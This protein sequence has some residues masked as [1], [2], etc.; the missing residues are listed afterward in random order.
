MCEG[1]SFLGTR[2]KLS[3]DDPRLP[4]AGDTA[5]TLTVV[6]TELPAA[7][8]GTGAAVAC[9]SERLRTTRDADFLSDGSALLFVV[10]V[11][12]AP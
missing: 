8:S 4:G 2:G 3:H 10:P 5:F 1:H 7:A 9:G 6:A 12:L 11:L